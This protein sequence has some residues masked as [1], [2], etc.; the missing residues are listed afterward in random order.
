MKKISHPLLSRTTKIV[1]SIFVLLFFPSS[2][3]H[4]QAQKDLG[5]GTFTLQYFYYPDGL[6]SND[7]TANILLKRIYYIKH[8]KVLV[9]T[10]GPPKKTIKQDTSTIVSKNNDG[11]IST[12]M[13]AKALYPIYLSDY[14]DKRYFMYFENT[15][16][17]YFFQDSLKNHPEDLYKPK[18]DQADKKTSLLVHE[19]E[20]YMIAGKPCLRAELATDGD[21]A[22]IY[23]TKEK[24]KFISPLNMPGVIGSIL[25][26]Y[27]KQKDGNVFGIFITHIKDEEMPDH[28][29]E[30]ERTAQQRTSNEVMS[31]SNQ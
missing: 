14:K 28:L 22:I 5:V 9:K 20:K 6:F 23:F 25:G 27:A 29:F 1:V 30:I 3:S 17:K 10:I 16:M 18:I 2:P 7:S 8:S 26:F 4:A 31:S 19:K 11:E 12:Q 13:S 21:T 24:I 15:K